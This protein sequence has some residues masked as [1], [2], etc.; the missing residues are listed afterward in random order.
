MY[1]TQNKRCG[2]LLISIAVH[3]GKA[4]RERESMK[5]GRKAY[6]CMNLV[7][8]SVWEMVSSFLMD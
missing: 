1:R 2:N 4:V 3:W 7:S 6:H 5:T 8:E